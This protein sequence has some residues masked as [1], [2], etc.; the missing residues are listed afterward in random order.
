MPGRR[1]SS[2]FE[3]LVVVAFIGSLSV[4]AVPRYRSV[5]ER[6]HIAVMRADL[7][8]I[9]TAQERFWSKNMHYSLDTVALRFT[10][11]STVRITLASANLVRGYS[12][13]A[14]HPEVPDV[15]CVTRTGP[16]AANVEAGAI[17]CSTIP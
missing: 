14:T 7:E 3:L 10:A 12:A 5:K 13:I 6:S 16:D 9:R 2:I 1:G 17:V 8:A 11:S 15:E 4:I